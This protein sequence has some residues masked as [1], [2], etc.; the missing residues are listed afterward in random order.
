MIISFDFDGT[1]AK[2]P[3]QTFFQKL[4][5]EKDLKLILVTSRCLKLPGSTIEYDH[6]DLFDITDKLGIDEKDIHFTNGDFKKDIL[7]NL[8]VSIHLDD[9]RMEIDKLG[10]TNI[11]PIDVN[12]S[13]WKNKVLDAIDALRSIN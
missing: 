7:I 6:S 2:T 3:V 8:G 1:L 10:C 4:K 11:I 5:Q 13:F 9:D 12:T